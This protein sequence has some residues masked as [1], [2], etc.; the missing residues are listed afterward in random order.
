MCK[1]RI[2]STAKGIKGVT[3]AMWD[4]DA[5]MI[6]LQFDLK[7]TSVDAVAKAIANA[8]HDNDK[9]KADD[10]VYNK[11]PACCKYRP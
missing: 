10:S 4:K 2:E 9:Y 5:Q 8:G 6:H 11:L 3:S 1:Q 7:Q